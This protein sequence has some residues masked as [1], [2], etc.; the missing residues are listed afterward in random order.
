[1][2][3]NDRRRLGSIKNI[4]TVAVIGLGYVGLPLA[5]TFVSKGHNVIGIDMNSEKI[6]NLRNGT[7]Y[8]SNLSEISFFRF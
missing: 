5:M 3:D 8:L 4:G 7:S 1:V 6:N 2:I